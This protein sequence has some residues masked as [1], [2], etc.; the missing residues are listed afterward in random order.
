MTNAFLRDLDRL[1]KGRGHR[2]EQH[3]HP[4][5]VGQHVKLLV[6]RMI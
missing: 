3:G 6:T 1:L 2:R 4:G 5:R